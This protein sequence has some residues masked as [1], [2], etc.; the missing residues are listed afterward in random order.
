MTTVTARARRT[1]EL[2]DQA[3][4]QG[5]LATWMVAV[6]SAEQLLRA[7]NSRLRFEGRIDHDPNRETAS[8]AP[9]ARPGRRRPSMPGPRYVPVERGT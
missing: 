3:E 2:V 4:S 1:A 9:E 8:D 7:L 5:G 6:S